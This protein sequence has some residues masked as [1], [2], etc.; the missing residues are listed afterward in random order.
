MT[1]LT[2][3]LLGLLVFILI[4]LIYL[5]AQFFSLRAQMQRL[6]RNYKYF[7]AGADGNSLEMTLSTEIKELREIEKASE[8]MLQQQELLATMQLRS[9]QKT[10]LVRYDAFDE[11]GNKLSFSLTLLDGRNNGVVITSLA[12]QESSRIYA[13]EVKLGQTKEALS[14]EEAESIN[15]AMQTLMPEMA[16]RAQQA[17]HEDRE[18]RENTEISE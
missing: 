9:Y 10:G 13:K 11:T 14:S 1:V 18:R 6:R 15:L 4:V 12:G 16:A 8:A 17:V 3:V 5:A 2:W 7:M